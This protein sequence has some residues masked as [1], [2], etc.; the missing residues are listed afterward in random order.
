MSLPP[1]IENYNLK[2]QGIEFS[3]LNS[4]Q[5]MIDFYKKVFQ[6][7]ISAATS[8][9]K[10]NFS[11][12]SSTSRASSTNT[13]EFL[14]FLRLDST[15]KDACMILDKAI[16]ILHFDSKDLSLVNGIR[17]NDSANIKE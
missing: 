12:S 10:D 4:S 14:S 13:S 8:Y 16:E 11:Y 5:F 15:I 3:T 1:D 17:K 7:H 9:L 2:S 6:A